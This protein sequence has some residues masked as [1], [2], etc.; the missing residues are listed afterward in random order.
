MIDIPAMSKM[1]MM[2]GFLLSQLRRMTPRAA[3]P[4]WPTS[5]LLTL[6]A[7]TPSIAIQQNWFISF[8]IN[9]FA[10]DNANVEA[11]RVPSVHC[12]MEFT[13]QAYM[14]TNHSFFIEIELIGHNDFSLAR[15]EL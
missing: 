10:S 3:L 2:V 12:W 11:F 8:Y 9:I 4:P 7:C 6:Q 5:P 15:R 14:A 1:E 13:Q